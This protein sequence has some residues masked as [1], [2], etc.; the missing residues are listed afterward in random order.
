MDNLTILVIQPSGSEES[1]T[2]QC[3]RSIAQT[4][5]RESPLTTARLNL[6]TDLCLTNQ[7][8]FIYSRVVELN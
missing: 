4:C 5:F 1:T 7:N 8:V 3:A 2:P 6:L